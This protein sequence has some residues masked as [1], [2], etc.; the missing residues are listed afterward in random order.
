MNWKTLAL[1]AG[2]LLILPISINAAESYQTNQNRGIENMENM[3]HHAHGA[4]RGRR[5][6][7]GQK[8]ERML[9]QLDLTPEQS[10]QIEIIKERSQTATEGLRE[11]AQTQKDEMQALLASDATTEEIRGQHQEAQNLRQQLDSNRLETM[12]EIR[13][14]LTPEQRAKMLEL[15]ESRQGRRSDRQES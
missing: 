1:T 7:R 4:K 10:Q 2:A 14:I 8:M 5:G 6:N 3:R 9:Q 13:E 11:E 12:L 15:K